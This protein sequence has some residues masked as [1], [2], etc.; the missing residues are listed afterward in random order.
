MTS[1]PLDHLYREVAF[2]AYHFHWSHD[3]IMDLEHGQRHE[4]VRRISEI[5]H[6]INQSRT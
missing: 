4:W 2:I 5:N 1:Y 3:E 6:E